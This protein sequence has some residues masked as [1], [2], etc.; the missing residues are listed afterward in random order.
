MSAPGNHDSCLAVVGMAVRLPGAPDLDAYWRNLAGG[1]ESITRWPPPPGAVHVPACGLLEG[2]DTFDAEL[3]GYAPRDALLIDPQ[4]RV[5]LECAWEALEH[6]GYDPARSPRPIGVYA[7]CSQTQYAELLRDRRDAELLA[8]VTEFALRLGCGLD[9]LTTRVAYKLGL[10]GPAVTVQTACSTSLVAIHLAGQALLAGECELALAGGV[11]VHVPAYPG[12]Y[13]PDGILS[14]DGHCRAFDA[15]AGG[16]IGGDGAG[17]VVLKRLDAALADGDTIHAVLLA[18]A[19]NNDGAD[20]IGYTAPSVTGQAEAIAT[21]LR[22]AGV[23]AQ[24][25]SYVEA[26]GTGTPLG[27]PIELAALTSAL[28]DPVAPGEL[29]SLCWLGSV[30]T[31]IGHT[32]AA[33]GV[34]GFIK[35]VL[36]LRERQLPPSLHFRS[37]NPAIDFGRF[38][39]NTRLRDWASPRS[40]RRAGV[41]SL[42]IGG[43]NAFALLEEAPGQVPAEARARAV[44]VARRPHRLVPVTGRNRRALA[45]AT[46]RLAGR[47]AAADPPDLADVAWTAQVGRRHHAHRRYVVAADTAGLVAGLTAGDAPTGYAA[48]PSRPVVFLFPGQGGQHVGMTRD[49]YAHEPVFAAGVDACAELL[50]G[51]LRADLREVLYGDPADPATVARLA[52][53][54]MAQ[55]CVFTV[56][57]ALAQLWRHWGVHPQAVVGHSLGAYAAACVAGVFELPDAVALV[58]ARGRLLQDLPDGAMIAVPLPERHVRELLGPGL[59]IAAVNGPQQ[60][61]VSGPRAAVDALLG[62]LRAR[63]VDARVLRISAAAHSVLVEPVI[64]RFR[65]AVTAL[66]RREPALPMVSD[67]SGAWLTGEQATDPG[68]WAAHLRGTVRF[69]DALA[70]LLGDGAPWVLLEVG[71]GRTLATLA[72]QHPDFAGRHAALTSLPHATAEAPEYPHLLDAAGR[73]WLA[74]HELEWAHLH[75]GETPRRVPLPTYPFQRMRYR[76]DPDPAVPVA[77]EPPPA[78]AS[79]TELDD[80]YVAP[81]TAT[82][83]AVAGSF[84]AILGVPRAGAHDSFLDLGGDSLIAAQLTAWIRRTYELSIPIRALFKTPTVAEL[85]RWIDA[86]LA[87][88]EPLAAPTPPPSAPDEPPAKEIDRV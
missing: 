48:Q 31:N 86:G 18:S 8:G 19:I 4:H 58:A 68:Y 29:E 69:S 73:L 64:A 85:A 25:V 34:A 43:T 78:D 70:T 87:S 77:I 5:F 66:E 30:K 2:P 53:M 35:V 71:P 62:T 63:E 81:R 50:A 20:K 7:G 56:E 12:E 24:T 9:F 13:T 3:F 42:G 59:A 26:H 38:E 47:L 46:A 84:V 83:H 1:V 75:D 17:V 40:P 52:P 72:Q 82:E 16:T 27:D 44:P 49:L 14:A 32:D 39:V 23:S 55:A 6:A 45:A 51:P 11:T 28:R 67:H 22:L 79:Q 74:G 33:A 80:A 65:A 21:A 57:Y 41:N 60:C 37:A 61:V 15:A 76:V 10:R 54:T 36:A 88:G